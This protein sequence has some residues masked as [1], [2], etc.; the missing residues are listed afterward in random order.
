MFYG[1][2]KLST[3]TMLAL[4][5]EFTSKLDCVYDWLDD[6]GTDASS[7]TLK[8]QDKNAYNALLSNEEYYLP[9]NW[10]KGFL[11]TTVLNKDGGEIK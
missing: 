3:V 11:G 5:S 6:A 10:K 7:R 4:D 8:V 1:C 9:D 2:T